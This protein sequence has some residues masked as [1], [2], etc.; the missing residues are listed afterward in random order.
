MAYVAFFKSNSESW[1]FHNQVVFS[2]QEVKKCFVIPNLNADLFLSCESCSL[3]PWPQLSTISWVLMPGVE[4]LL[5]RCRPD[6]A[7]WH[8]DLSSDSFQP[9]CI[10]TM[11]TLTSPPN[12][13]L[14]ARLFLYLAEQLCHWHSP[15]HERTSEQIG[16]DTLTCP[17]TRRTH[18]ERLGWTRWRWK[19]ERG[20]L[21]VHHIGVYSPRI[22][23]EVMCAFALKYASKSDKSNIN[24]MAVL[25][26]WH[27]NS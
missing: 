21:P 4:A 9:V 11:L 25:K 7:A 15:T 27:L 20:G 3:K 26:G 8:H 18:T 19:P 2:L 14:S 12:P 1:L 23:C 5:W 6:D 17:H 16:K 24:F 13:R 10:L 22:L